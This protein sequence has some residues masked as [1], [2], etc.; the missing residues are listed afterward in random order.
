MKLKKG[1]K[2]TGIYE[3]QFQKFPLFFKTIYGA[4]L[5]YGILPGDYKGPTE[6]FIKN[7]QRKISENFEVF[8]KIQREKI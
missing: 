7:Y 3:T 5:S 1:G 2:F 4:R 8:K 6:N